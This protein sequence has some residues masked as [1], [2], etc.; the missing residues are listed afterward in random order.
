MTGNR[1]VI[2]VGIAQLCTKHIRLGEVV[3]VINRLTR[4]IKASQIIIGSTQIQIFGRLLRRSI[5]T[6]LL[7]T[8][9][10]P[11]KII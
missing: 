3:A 8:S 9:P 10:I 4:Y 7:E 2:S 5:T 11:V 6:S 1:L